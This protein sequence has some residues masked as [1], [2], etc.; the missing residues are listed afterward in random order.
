MNGAINFVEIKSLDRRGN[1]ISLIIITSFSQTE[2]WRWVVQ[3]DSDPKH[4][5]KGLEKKQMKVI[6]DQCPD[7]NPAEDLW[8]STDVERICKGDP[9]SSLGSVFEYQ[10]TGLFSA[11]QTLTALCVVQAV[12][13]NYS[14]Q[15]Y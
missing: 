8:T 5:S 2:S 6:E 4:T 10:D 1:I 12:W 7:L 13:L 3:Q 11:D 15:R 14:N 9:G